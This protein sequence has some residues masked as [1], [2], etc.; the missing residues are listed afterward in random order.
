MEPEGASNKNSPFGGRE[1]QKQKLGVSLL[2]QGSVEG[3]FWTM[4][5]LSQICRKCTSVT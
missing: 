2:P 3:V 4:C 1:Q 5:E